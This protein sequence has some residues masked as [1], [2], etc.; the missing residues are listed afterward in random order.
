LLIVSGLG[1]DAH[2][3]RVFYE[4]GASL[5]DAASKLGVPGTNIFFLSENP[6]G[7]RR[8]AGA[9]TRDEIR[10][11]LSALGGRAG[12]GSALWVVL[13]GHGSDRGEPRLSLPGPDLS[14]RELDSMLGAFSEWKVAVINTTSASGGF[15]P[16]LSRAGRVVITATRSGFEQNQT[17][18]PKFFVEAFAGSGADLNKDGKVSLLEAFVYARNGVR[19]YYEAD[20]RLLT[21]H[22]MLDDSGDGTGTYEP[23]EF[24]GDG[25]LAARMFLDAGVAPAAVADAELGALLSRKDSLEARIA[26]LRS[27]R[28]AMAEE[29]YERQ[30]EELL[31]ELALV[32]RAIRE[33]GGR[34]Q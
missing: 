27:L 24:E 9:P 11:I 1:G 7:D 20:Q 25:A 30:L 26:E 12:R 17:I 33:R 14:A 10:R 4:W 31:V 28:G 32:D 34:R 22:A 18:F 6:A 5:A 19:R 21:E 2:Y 16:V 29:E 15:L 23:S 13:I 8:V 3:S